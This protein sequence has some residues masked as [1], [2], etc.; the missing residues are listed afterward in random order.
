MA[1]LTD[2]WAVIYRIF[3]MMTPNHQMIHRKVTGKRKRFV[4][5]LG[6]GMSLCCE[7]ISQPNQHPEYL[8][9][10]IQ[11]SILVDAAVGSDG[12]MSSTMECIS[13][14][15]HQTESLDSNVPVMRLRGGAH[16]I[17]NFCYQNGCIYIFQ[18]R[19][20]TECANER[21]SALM[22]INLK[23]PVGIVDNTNI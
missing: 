22:A 1:L 16:R 20:D 13:Q 4:R 17:N 18:S 6:G 2:N 15:V 23:V 19:P 10:L 8:I 12:D 11:D 14:S 7:Y 3:L 21:Q 5:C 9:S